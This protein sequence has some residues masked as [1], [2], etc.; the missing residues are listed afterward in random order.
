MSEQ[1][2]VV[3]QTQNAPEESVATPQE[4]QALEVDTSKIF[5][6][7]YNEGRS[8]AEKDL[9]GKFSSL[10]IENVE[11]VEDAISR[12]SEQ[13]TPK[14]EQESEVQQLRSMLEEANRKAQEAEDEREAF[15]YETRLD[16]TM[17]DAIDSL[18]AE[19][20][21]TLESAHLKNL[22]YME[23]EIEERDGQ[24]YPVK[25]GTPVLDNEGNLKSV[26]TVMRDFVR[27][28]KY[29]NAKVQGT[30]GGTG[31]GA[32]SSKP[33]R[34]EF[35]Q[36]VRSKSKDGQTRAAELWTQAKEVGWA[37]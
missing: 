33:S 16:K 19:G 6:K 37:P 24:F 2:Q 36:L 18:T 11:S 31:D 8:K 22:F 20:N 35:Q 29:I 28:Y 15:I 13:L 27:E 12:L 14:K 4:Q 23:Y 3:E 17:N 25:N 1:D 9:L 5:S 30:G 34:A 32:S 7:G 21:L 10:G 26:S